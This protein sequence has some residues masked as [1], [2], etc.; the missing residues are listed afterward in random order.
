M[1]QQPL[2]ARMKLKLPLSL[3]SPESSQI[4][5]LP[6]SWWVC[7]AFCF[8]PGHDFEAE[9]LGPELA[10]TAGTGGLDTAGAAQEMGPEPRRGT[11]DFWPPP[12]MNGMYVSMCVYS[13]RSDE[14]ANYS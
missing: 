12:E 2:S 9:N 4:N 8:P 14:A 10:M 5:P 1:Q 13:L 11:G 3:P 6:C 7:R